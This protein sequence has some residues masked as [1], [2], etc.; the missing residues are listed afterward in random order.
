M[1]NLILFC[2]LFV[3][4]VA[5][6]QHTFLQKLKL[7]NGDSMTINIADARVALLAP[8][9]GAK[10]TLGGP[11]VSKTIETA[12]TFASVVSASCGNL[13]TVTRRNPTAT[14]AINPMWIDKVVKSSGNTY[15]LV[16]FKGEPTPWQVV[17]TFANV[18]ALIATCVSSG[19]SSG[20]VTSGSPLQGDGSSGDP[21]TF[22]DGTTAG[23]VW[24]WDGST[25]ALD[26]I[27]G[28]G[29]VT[30]YTGDGTVPAATNRV[31]GLGTGSTLGFRYSN[32]EDAA[33][34][35]DS[36]GSIFLSSGGGENSVLIDESTSSGVTIQF[37]NDP[38]VGRFKAT[39]IDNMSSIEIERTYAALLCYNYDGTTFSSTELDSFGVVTIRS[40][41]S[42][43][44]SEIQL[45]GGNATTTYQSSGVFRVADNDGST[46]FEMSQDQA[47]LVATSQFPT[48]QTMGVYIDTTSQNFYNNRTGNGVGFVDGLGSGL[49]IQLANALPI[50]GQTLVAG[51]DNTYYFA[52]RDTLT[53]DNLLFQSRGG[54]SY[55][56]GSDGSVQTGSSGFNNER[57]AYVQLDSFGEANI[58]SKYPGCDYNYLGFNTTQIGLTVE[59]DGH[60]SSEG[61]YLVSNSS[62]A[63]NFAGGDNGTEP[64]VTPDA[65]IGTGASATI[66]RGSDYRFT[67]IVTT[68]TAPVAS[69]IFCHVDFDTAFPDAPYLVLQAGNDAS[70][71]AGLYI[72]ASSVTTFGFDVYSRG[73]ATISVSTDYVFTVV[74]TR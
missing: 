2:L 33:V 72:L 38:N 66:D 42:G 12:S 32:T 11:S 8:S 35:D 34:F 74:A 53:F 60:S 14:A 9:G 20:T 47:D 7:L 56:D 19:G 69:G 41:I 65:G 4:S 73:T 40:E 6:S 1:K 59:I 43:N 61:Q 25:W 26:T 70:A 64:T 30:I 15:A 23:Q 27:A 39:S 17:G 5:Y 21:L 58:R 44:Q 54:F 63:F 37:S 16:Y 31:L 51:T 13:V 55:I 28:G 45:S 52:S 49:Y 24:M 68:G 48:Q 29:G 62:G 18:S 10:I 71:E 3:T 46:Y 67:A 22:E 36:Q 57:Q 50:P